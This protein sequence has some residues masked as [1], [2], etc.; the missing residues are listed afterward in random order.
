[1]GDLQIG[2]TVDWYRI[3]GP[4]IL[5]KHLSDNYSVYQP[6]EVTQGNTQWLKVTEE[7]IADPLLSEPPLSSP[8][9]FFFC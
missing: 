8:K 6:I 1:M 5:R 7:E 3:D 4:E 2:K 9:S